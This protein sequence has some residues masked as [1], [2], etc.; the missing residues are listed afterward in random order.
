[1]EKC[2]LLQLAMGETEPL[3]WTAAELKDRL[4]YMKDYEVMWNVVSDSQ[5]IHCFI[6]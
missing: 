3:P 4:A 2:V 6:F 5:I 1:M